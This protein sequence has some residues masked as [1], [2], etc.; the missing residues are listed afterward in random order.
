MV[1]SIYIVFLFVLLTINT[2]AHP[3]I[4]LVQDSKGNVYFSDLVHVWKISKAGDVSIAVENVH[5]HQLYID[6]DDNLYGEH[7]WY[8]GEATDKWVHR[9]WCLK[10]DGSL[11]DVIPPTEGFPENNT[12]KKDMYGNEYYQVKE[13]DFDVLMQK[14]INGR[15]SKFSTHNFEDIRW[16]C[17]D[18]KSDEILVVDHLSVKKVKCDGSVELLTDDLKE[19][20]LPFFGVRDKHYLMGTWKDSKKN[21]YVAVYGAKKVKRI[22]ADGQVEDVLTSKDGWSP[23]AGFIDEEENLWILEYSKRN[24]SRVR[25]IS[26]EGHSVVFENN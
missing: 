6:A 9:V 2:K 17:A 23:S 21:V 24:K 26:K 8:E 20:S 7:V 14:S 10:H 18:S 5:T 4:G 15:I 25:K 13:G 16:I 1:R 22:S 12:L 3:A 11:S 19:E